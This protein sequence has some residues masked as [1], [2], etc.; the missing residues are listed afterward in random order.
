MPFA[1]V[2]HRA[3]RAFKSNARGNVAMIASLAVIPILTVAGIAVDL[4]MTTTQKSKVQSALDSAVLAASKGMQEGKSNEQVQIEASAYFNAILSNS[5]ENMLDCEELQ[6]VYVDDT[7]EL[8]ATVHCQHDT[9]L[10]QIAGRE[11]LE[12]QVNT[13][14][15]YGIGKLDVAFV[16]DVS[17]SMDSNNR[18]TNLKAAALEAVDTLLPEVGQLGEPGDVRLSMVSYDSMVNAASFHEAVTD[19]PESRTYSWTGSV[20]TRVRRG[21]CDRWQTQT[22]TKTITST[23]VSERT[24]TDQFTDDAPGSGSWLTPLEPV[25]DPGD[26]RWEY[27]YYD[28]STEWTSTQIDCNDDVVVPLTYERKDLTDFID[29]MVPSSGTAGHLGTAWGMYLL[30]PDWNSVWP[31]GSV[32]LAYDEPDSAKAIILMTDGSFNRWYDDGEG[33]SFEQNMELCDTLKA[34]GV[35]VFTVAFE[36]PTAGQ[37]HLAECASGAEFAFNPENGQ[38]LT[39]T[40]LTIAQSISDL[41]ISR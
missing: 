22:K 13:A 30:S 2:V 16:F 31:S 17:G 40:Y 39:D 23:C 8:E 35:I 20:C 12:F 6:L 37:E 9:T 1:S 21:V 41:R 25:Y 27:R 38:E 3:L 28:G 26:D 34:N 4:Q 7:Q 18:M 24:G 10:T 36:A 19:E 5:N 11:Y 15:T 33:S 29:A 32:G 14:S